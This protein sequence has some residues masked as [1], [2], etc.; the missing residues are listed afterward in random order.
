MLGK[1][2]DRITNNLIVYLIKAGFIDEKPYRTCAS[3]YCTPSDFSLDSNIQIE[4]CCRSN[5]CNS[6]S[7]KRKHTFLFYLNYFFK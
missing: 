5:F 7:R 2:Y 6:I 3:R 4:T 1:N